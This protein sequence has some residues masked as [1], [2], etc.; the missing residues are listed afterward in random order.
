MQ[1]HIL[2]TNEFESLLLHK[3][4][5]SWVWDTNGKKYLDCESG[6]WCVNLGHNHPKTVEAI[7]DQADKIWHRNKMFLTPATL[8][9]AERLLNFLPN[10]YDKITFLNSG[11]EAME[12]SISFAKKV[13][14][15]EK[16]LSLQDSYLGAYGQS[17]ES[18][19]TSSKQSKLKIRYPICDKTD[20]DCLEKHKESIDFIFKTNKDEIACFVL[21]PIMVSG[22]IF[23]PC[24]SFIQYICE[25]TK[26]VGGLVVIDEVTT[27]F[28]RTGK[29]FGYEI[30]EITPDVIV[31]GKALGNGYPVSAVIT[32]SQFETKCSSSELYYAQSHQLDPLGAAIVNSVIDVFAEEKI[33][34]NIQSKINL[35]DSF[36]RS[37]T[38]PCIKEVRSFGMIF[39]IQI[40]SSSNMTT[41]EII[42]T[43]KNK[44]LQEGIIIGYSTQK[45][46]IRL[47]PPLTIKEEEI[48]ILK[49]KMLKV[50]SSI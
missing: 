11:S 24:A 8:E 34:E 37:L 5:G 43:I 17:K 25:K 35:L 49:K 9:A 40:K 41:E 19:F 38:H 32:Q 47:L 12:F 18:S 7:K 16:V 36:F 28:G 2:K 42:Y 33:L 15:R 45:E 29:K 10:D 30:F 48:K 22:G 31:L 6:M 23:K 4:V 21:E 26:N 50:L 14:K 13:T 39:A 3:A 27:G 46:L 1:S 44:L 20:C